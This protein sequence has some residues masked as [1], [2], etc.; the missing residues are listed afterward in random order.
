MIWMKRILISL[1]TILALLGMSLYFF[2]NSLKPIYEGEKTIK[3]LSSET[4]TYFDNF[5]IPHIEAEN[6]K[7]AMMALGYVHAQERLWQIELVRRIAPGRLSEIFGDVMIN[8]DKLF[9]TLGIDEHSQKTVDALDKKDPVVILAQAYVDGVNEYIANGKTPLE[10]TILGIEKTQ[11]TI[12]DIFNIYGYMAF[13]FA[14]AHKTDPLMTQIYD[15]YGSE[16]LK[17]LGIYSDFNF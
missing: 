5:G 8:N 11:F 6:E 3:G 17:D 2:L 7:D 16:Y 9:A 1:F 12:K 10:F 15:K 13:S 4:K 14:M